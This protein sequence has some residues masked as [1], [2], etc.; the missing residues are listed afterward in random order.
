VDL[1]LP[2]LWLADEARGWWQ[3]RRRVTVL[4]H[5]AIFMP[6][7]PEHYFMKGGQPIAKS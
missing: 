3:R 2:V 6:A 5:R 1:V 4:V 7:S